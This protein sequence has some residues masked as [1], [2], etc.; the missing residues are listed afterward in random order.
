MCE[1]RG[2]LCKSPRCE[3]VRRRDGA[4]CCKCNS[5][6]WRKNRPYQAAF[7]SLRGNAKAR[8]I[9]FT[10]TFDYF[11]A[12]AK[13]TGY[14]ERKGATRDCLTVDR[15]DNLRGYAPGNIQSLTRAQNSEKWA[16]YDEVRIARPVPGRADA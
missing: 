10:L 1:G 4:D 12:F 14:V 5:R 9:E 13:A 3:N 11:Y 8:G 2:Q 7:A 15:I 6:A 16:R